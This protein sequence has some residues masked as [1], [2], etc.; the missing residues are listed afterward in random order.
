MRWLAISIMSLANWAASRGRLGIIG[1]RHLLYSLFE[2]LGAPFCDA[3]GNRE[4]DPLGQ[5]AGFFNGR[6]AGANDLPRPLKVRRDKVHFH[7]P[8][9]RPE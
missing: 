6:S 3:L 7:A 1:C 5:F 9:M 2:T 8:N 4:C